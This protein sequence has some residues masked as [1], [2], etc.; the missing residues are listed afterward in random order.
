MAHPDE[1]A[2]M[3]RG[4]IAPLMDWAI[5]ESGVYAI[6]CGDHPVTASP[7]TCFERNDVIWTNGSIV[8]RNEADGTI[9]ST[10]S[11]IVPGN[12]EGL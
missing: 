10:I 11:K 2:K 7:V 6:R 12:V 4:H 8:V 5:E 9:R 1:H 3:G